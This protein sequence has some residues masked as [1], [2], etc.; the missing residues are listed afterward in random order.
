MGEK[1]TGSD[2]RE[3]R[4]RG[5]KISPI[6]LV[7]KMLHDTLGLKADTHTVTRC[8]HFTHFAQDRWYPPSE[9]VVL[10]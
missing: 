5:S 3:D 8:A 1:H 4:D 10:I 2:L 9:S 6:T 7:T